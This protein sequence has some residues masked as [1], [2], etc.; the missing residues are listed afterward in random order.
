MGIFLKSEIVLEAAM[1]SLNTLLRLSGPRNSETRQTISEE[2]ADGPRE[3]ATTLVRWDG[4]LNDPS[5]TESGFWAGVSAMPLSK[6]CEH[7]RQ[8]LWNR[9]SVR[10]HLIRQVNVEHAD[11]ANPRSIQG[12]KELYE[13]LGT[14]ELT[15]AGELSAWSSYEEDQDYEQDHAMSANRQAW[16]TELLKRIEGLETHVVSLI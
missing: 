2:I 7:Y 6:I 12:G 3:L 4:I 8:Y 10:A 13:R 14:V 9:A 16:W 1:I 15:T 11:E 5:D